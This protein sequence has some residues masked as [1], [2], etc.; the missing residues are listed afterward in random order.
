M[1]RENLIKEFKEAVMDMRK[2]HHNG[3]YHW[4]LHTDEKNNDWAIV[5]GWQDGF[6][7]DETDDC[8]YGTYRL[9]SKLAYQPHNSMLQCGYD[10]DWLMPYNEKTGEVDDNELSIYP[11]TDL[12]GII[13]WLLKCYESYT[14]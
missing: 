14:E 9:C 7:E 8:M 2:N 6:E 5:L 4:Y 1:K 13:D 10:I 12:E 11:N 3:T